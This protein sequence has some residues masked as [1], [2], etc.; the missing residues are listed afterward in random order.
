M[1]DFDFQQLQTSTLIKRI[2]VAV[3]KVYTIYFKSLIV[4][5]GNRLI[6]QRFPIS[7]SEKQMM[8]PPTHLKRRKNDPLA[9]ETKDTSAQEEARRLHAK[10]KTEDNSHNQSWLSAI[11]R[12]GDRNTEI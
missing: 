1:I 6:E 8:T 10:T 9:A 3:Y 7:V 11:R 2:E 4:S 5:T 12:S